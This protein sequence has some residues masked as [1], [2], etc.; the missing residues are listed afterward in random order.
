MQLDDVGDLFGRCGKQ[1]VSKLLAHFP[2]FAHAVPAICSN[3]PAA[4][5][6]RNVELL[7]YTEFCLFEILIREFTRSDFLDG[8]M[9]DLACV[10]N[11][12]ISKGV[13]IK[14]ACISAECRTAPICSAFFADAFMQDFV[15]TEHRCEC[16]A[17]RMR[18]DVG[19]CVKDLCGKGDLRCDR[20]SLRR[21]AC[22]RIVEFP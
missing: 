7:D 4:R 14:L 16:E 18:V 9:K 6:K 12:R 17:C 21:R 19:D 5:R 8:G 1:P 10:C 11:S 22:D 2:G 3:G 13:E 15:F 20:A